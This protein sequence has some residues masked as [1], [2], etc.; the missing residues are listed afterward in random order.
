MMMMMMR[1][2]HHDNARRGKGDENRDAANDKKSDLEKLTCTT[3]KWMAQKYL[4][5]RQNVPI[6]Q[7]SEST[8]KFYNL[9]KFLGGLK[10]S[11]HFK[12]AWRGWDIFHPT[13]TYSSL[14]FNLKCGFRV[15]SFF[16]YHHP[17]WCMIVTGRTKKS[18]FL[19][20]SF[21]KWPHL[22]AANDLKE[23]R[24]WICQKI[25]HGF[26]TNQSYI[27]HSWFSLNSL[28]LRHRVQA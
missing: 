9:R 14:K 23:Q 26:P 24:N 27:C 20:A 8:S 22:L 13:H 19:R 12:K 11:L 3:S 15:F 25:P 7:G 10:C 5:I 17:L 2:T 4:P 16:F 28:F 6:R 21:S 1:G 18:T